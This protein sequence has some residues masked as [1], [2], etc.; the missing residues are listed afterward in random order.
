MTSV[1]DPKMNQTLSSIEKRVPRQLPDSR[2][3]W[4]I[5]LNGSVVKVTE[6]RTRLPEILTELEHTL[7]AK[8]RDH[9]NV[10]IEH[11]DM[12]L[13]PSNGIQIG[14]NRELYGLGVESVAAITEVE[15]E[16]LGYIARATTMGVHSVGADAVTAAVDHELAKADNQNKL[17]KA[18]TNRRAELFVWLDSPHLRIAAF[19]ALADDGLNI[20]KLVG[21]PNLPDGITAVWTAP[22]PV[23]EN[24][25]HYW[26]SDGGAWKSR[27]W[28]VTPILD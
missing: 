27:L 19:H 11:P 1:T 21:R 13:A 23:K 20:E 4:S 12:G 26:H 3:Y 9:A 25:G 5:T 28:I 18:G 15:P 6:L 2:F 14:L 16:H 22:T 7:F 17:R 24:S 10:F 8:V